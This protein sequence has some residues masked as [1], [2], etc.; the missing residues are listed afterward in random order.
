MEYHVLTEKTIKKS[1]AN[2][3]LFSDC[4]QLI[5]EMKGM[6]LPVQLICG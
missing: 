4:Q 5:P 3:W 2:A 1:H 6:E